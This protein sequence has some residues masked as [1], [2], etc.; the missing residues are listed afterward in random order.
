[1]V[2][3]PDDVPQRAKDKVAEVKEFVSRHVLDNP[4]SPNYKRRFDDSNKVD[5]YYWT[6][7]PGKLEPPVYK[8]R[9]SK[10]LVEP[11]SRIAN[12]HHKRPDE[13]WK[14]D[15]C[16]TRKF[17][18]QNA[19]NLASSGAAGWNRSTL[20]TLA[21]K[22]RPAPKFKK[23]KVVLASNRPTLIQRENRRLR[24]QRED[25]AVKRK[26]AKFIKSNTVTEDQ[27]REESYQILEKTKTGT[28]T[29]LPP[30]G[31][32]DRAS[33]KQEATENDSQGQTEH[34]DNLNATYTGETL[35]QF[36]ETQTAGDT[37][38]PQTD[39]IGKMLKAKHDQDAVLVIAASRRRK[40]AFVYEYYH[41]GKW[42]FSRIE[43]EMAWSC[44]M[45]N[46]NESQGCECKSKNVAAWQ[47]S[48]YC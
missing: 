26:Y 3:H 32:G 43:K 27:M 6:K 38:K 35:T 30:S 29:V 33:T 36:L 21:E 45:N 18:D 2:F 46:Y 23:A 28:R 41:P 48:S 17:C 40:D 5:R 10:T 39:F 8:T 34:I 7:V 19:Q 42:E 22:K 9:M 14:Y 20:I 13:V 1:M 31:S 4:R 47:V 16:D 11:N 44:C 24:K 37:Y 25:K 15:T 12:P